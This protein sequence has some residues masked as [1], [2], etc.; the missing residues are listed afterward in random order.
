MVQPAVE[1][2]KS[3]QRQFY[4]EKY[5]TGRVAENGIPPNMLV[6]HVPFSPANNVHVL[7]LVQHKHLK[8]MKRKQGDLILQAIKIIH[9]KKKK[10]F[11]NLMAAFKNTAAFGTLQLKRC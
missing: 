10:C 1:Y 3:H 11:S 9:F 7:W 4:L 6:N 5:T 2:H 8:N